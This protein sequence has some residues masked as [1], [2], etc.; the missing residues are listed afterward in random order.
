MMWIRKAMHEAFVWGMLAL[1]A[2]CVLGVA[3][4]V[5]Y[6]IAHFAGAW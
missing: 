5:T 2:A 6:G 1:A 4:V 3:V